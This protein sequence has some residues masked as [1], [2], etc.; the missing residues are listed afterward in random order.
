MWFP[1]FENREGW[2]SLSYSSAEKRRKRAGVQGGL[3]G[4]WM[5]CSFAFLRKACPELVEG[6]GNGLTAGRFRASVGEGRSC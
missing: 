1:P 5:P 3:A 2:G 4:P 6:R